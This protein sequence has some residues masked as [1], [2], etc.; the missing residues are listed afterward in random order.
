MENESEHANSHETEITAPEGCSVV[1]KTDGTRSSAGVVGATTATT[2]QSESPRLWSEPNFDEGTI[3]TTTTT[4]QQ[5]ESPKL[6]AEPNFD[7]GTITTAYENPQFHG[8]VATQPRSID[9]V[10]DTGSDG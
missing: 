2:R 10:G 6:S 9:L 1:A 8:P 4:T 3:T 5:S 7:E